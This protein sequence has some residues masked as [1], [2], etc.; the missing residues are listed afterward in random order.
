MLLF[1]PPK[2]RK[3]RGHEKREAQAAHP[4]PPT[5]LTLVAATYS[6]GDLRVRLVFDRAIDIAGI[7]GS[8]IFVADADLGVEF[9][10]DGAAATLFDATTVDVGLAELGPVGGELVKLTATAASGIVAVDDG[11]TWAGVFELALPFP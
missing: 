11:G 7:E 2:F 5:A 3:R 10:G 8:Q 6:D 4:A 9:D 1:P